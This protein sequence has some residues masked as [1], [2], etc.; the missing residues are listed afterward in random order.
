MRGHRLSRQAERQDC[1]G[2]KAQQGAG[3]CIPL[4]SGIWAVARPAA[5]TPVPAAALC[6]S[7]QGKCSRWAALNGQAIL[8]G[9]IIW[10]NVLEIPDGG[11]R[12]AVYLLHT[13]QGQLCTNVG[14][15]G[16]AGLGS[17]MC[18]TPAA[19]GPPAGTYPPCFHAQRWKWCSTTTSACSTTNRHAHACT[20]MLACADVEDELT[21]LKYPGR[22]GLANSKEMIE[23]IRCLLGLLTEDKDY[24]R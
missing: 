17:A 12:T 16:H 3:L 20:A 4:H 14:R 11:S 8:Q 9:N 18:G 6:S 19:L 10:N 7:G 2:R 23:C 13:G 5:H 24:P 21:L 15:V 1:A 22:L